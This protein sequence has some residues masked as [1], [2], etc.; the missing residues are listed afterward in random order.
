MTFKSKL[1]MQ[2][3]FGLSLAALNKTGETDSTQ[4]LAFS[5]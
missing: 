2:N 4:L 1:T 3:I 5:N